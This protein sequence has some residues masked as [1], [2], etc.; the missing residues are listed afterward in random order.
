MPYRSKAQERWAHTPEG[1]KALGNKLAE[2]DAASKGMKLPE[3]V[4]PA[5]ILSHATKRKR[6]KIKF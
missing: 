2:F 5:G 3:R 4:K 1:R 6:G